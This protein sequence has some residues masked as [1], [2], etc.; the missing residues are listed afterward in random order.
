MIRDL[1]Y[2]SLLVWALWLVCRGW[3][4]K[5]WLNVRRAQD[6]SLWV[7]ALLS[8][9]GHFVLALVLLLIVAGLTCFDWKVR[10]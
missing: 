8:F 2:C 4:V 7:M 5:P 1:G 3:N 10:P 9:S 6:I